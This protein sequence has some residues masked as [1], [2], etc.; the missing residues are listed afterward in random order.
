MFNISRTTLVGI[1][2]LTA[3]IIKLIFGLEIPKEVQES[4]IV[5]LL[6]LLGI[7]AQ[8]QVKQEKEQVKKRG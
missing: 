1:V 3:G 8:D 5:I 7:F 6:F 4:F 2:A